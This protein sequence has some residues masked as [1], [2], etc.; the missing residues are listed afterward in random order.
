MQRSLCVGSDLIWSG[1]VWAGPVSTVV[2]HSFCGG[3]ETVN[4]PRRSSASLINMLL[5]LS[6]A[7]A[8]AA[9]PKELLISWVGGSWVGLF[10]LPNERHASVIAFGP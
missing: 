1:L 6:G 5:V 2:N 9:C 7:Q 10:F 4:P 3:Q 8:C